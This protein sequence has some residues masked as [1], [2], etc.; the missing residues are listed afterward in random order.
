MINGTRMGPAVA[1]AFRTLDQMAGGAVY[2]GIGA[3]SVGYRT[4]RDA[5][6]APGSHW[7]LDTKLRPGWKYLPL[8]GVA[9]GLGLGA[10][11]GSRDLYAPPEMSRDMYSPLPGVVNPSLSPVFQHEHL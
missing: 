10:Y 3:A 7:I 11:R 9:A 1:W 4:A 5:L 6:L 2:A 8:A